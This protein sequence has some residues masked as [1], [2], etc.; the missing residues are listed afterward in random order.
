MHSALAHTLALY[1]C[2]RPEQYAD[3]EVTTLLNRTSCMKSYEGDTF[4]RLHLF[5]KL[6]YDFR[7]GCFFASAEIMLTMG[8]LTKTPGGCSV[9]S[10]WRCGGSVYER[11]AKGGGAQ[12]Q[13]SGVNT[14][15]E[16]SEGG[17]R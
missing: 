17:Q 8:I 14:L 4:I 13:R 5:V 11:K 1:K 9:H 6:L 2:I 15:R 3:V 16:V 7:F 10:V 12:A